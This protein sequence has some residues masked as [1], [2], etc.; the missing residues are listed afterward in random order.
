M[1]KAWGGQSLPSLH[2]DDEDSH[3]KS[4]ARTVKKLEKKLAEVEVRQNARKLEKA[5]GGQS[6]PSL[7]S[8]SR[9]ID[10]LG[11]NESNFLNKPIPSRDNV[12]KG[13][14][15]KAWEDD[16]SCGD[17]NLLGGSTS[18]PS[19]RRFRRHH[20]MKKNRRAIAIGNIFGPV[21]S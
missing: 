11:Q 12:E 1:G 9:K 21:L 3:G 19:V 4:M 14:T 2:C 15:Q 13:H 17:L 6:L 5:W 16:T 10:T 20:D 18:V 8:P 7:H